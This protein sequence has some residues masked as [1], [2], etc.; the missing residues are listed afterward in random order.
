MR[1]DCGTGG[2]IVELLDEFNLCLLQGYSFDLTFGQM[3][4]EMLH[5]RGGVYVTRRPEAGEH[6][7][8]ARIEKRSF[9]AGDAFVALQAPGTRVTGRKRYQFCIFA[10]PDF[11]EK[12]PKRTQEILP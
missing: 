6:G 1:L 7:A 9:Q 12:P 10:F 11:S 4:V 5:Q 2:L 8:S 3:M